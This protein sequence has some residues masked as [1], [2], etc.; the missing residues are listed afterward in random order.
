MAQYRACMQGMRGEVSR[1]GSKA[2]G[3]HT[4][5]DAWDIGIHTRLVHEHGEDV[6]YVTLT[7]G[8]NGMHSTQ[9]IGTYKRINGVPNKVN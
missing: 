4:S 6:V 5:T 9:H 8:S 7:G 1:L 3:I 2:S